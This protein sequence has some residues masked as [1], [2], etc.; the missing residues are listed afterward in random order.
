MCN[1]WQYLFSQKHL[2]GDIE[3]WTRIK[4][5]FSQLFIVYMLW[6]KDACTS[7]RIFTIAKNKSKL[8]MESPEEGNQ[9]RDGKILT[10]WGVGKKILQA[11]R[12]DEVK[13]S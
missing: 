5:S 3:Y 13:A 8:C 12:E 10:T 9:R 11:V 2:L 4:Y 7:L 6:E 1:Y